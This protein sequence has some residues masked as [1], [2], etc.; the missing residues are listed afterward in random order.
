MSAASDFRKEL[1]KIM[2]GFVWTVHKAGSRALLTATGIRSS[3]FNR[4]STLR[5]TRREYLNGAVFYDAKSAGFGRRAEW[6]HTNTDMT[7]ARALR[8]LQ[9]YYE[10]KE[11]VYRS[12]AASLRSGRI[13]D[14]SERGAAE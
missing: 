1:V 14:S 8:G 12:L 3:G 5:V 2:P 6:V 10:E 13:A 9:D 4:L 11:R 7:A